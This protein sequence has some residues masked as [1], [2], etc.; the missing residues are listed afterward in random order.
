MY[1]IIVEMAFCC[2]IRCRISSERTGV[3]CACQAASWSISCIEYLQV[4]YSNDLGG[5][6]QHNV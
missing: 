5:L 3:L 6:F 1:S 2:F 4:A